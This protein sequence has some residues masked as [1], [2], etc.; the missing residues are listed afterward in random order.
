MARY[1]T[2]TDLTRLGLPAVA[3]EGISSDDQQAALDAASSTADGYL[4]SRFRLPLTAW[5][6]D[7]TRAVC[8]IAAYD[9]MVTRGMAP[10]S[11]EAELLGDRSRGALA[12]L[13]DVADGRVT[14]VVTETSPAVLGGA[15]VE[16]NTPRGW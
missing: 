7:L 1:A 13:R 9:L 10:G 15:R 8:Q 6:E 16:S 4:A 3:L 14:P 5:G 12:W 11:G 2:T